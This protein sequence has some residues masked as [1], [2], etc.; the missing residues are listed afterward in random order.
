MRSTL[1]P[2]RDKAPP[3]PRN[4]SILSSIPLDGL[5]LA[6][7]YTYVLAKLLQNG[8]KFRK[9]LTHTFKNYMGHLDNFRQAVENP[10]S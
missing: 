6:Q 3:F 9:K 1:L 10:K 7:L 8:A 5:L 4:P 2:I